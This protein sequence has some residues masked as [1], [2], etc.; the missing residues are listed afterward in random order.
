M[1]AVMRD[2]QV[3]AK[4]RDEM[5]K[6]AAPYLHPKLCAVEQRVAAQ[7]AQGDGGEVIVHVGFVQGQLER[8]GG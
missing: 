8:T 7:D 2:P 5:A 4:R 1:L 3:D 6:A